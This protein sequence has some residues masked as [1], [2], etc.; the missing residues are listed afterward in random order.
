M[1]AATKL[2]FS[3]TPPWRE[4]KLLHMKRTAL[5][6]PRPVDPVIAMPVGLLGDYL[7]REEIPE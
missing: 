2:I 6:N 1:R 7:D 3:T 4:G 5:H